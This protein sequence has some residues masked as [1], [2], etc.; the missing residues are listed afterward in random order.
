MQQLIPALAFPPG[1]I[2]QE[3]LEASGLTQQDLG[4]I[5]EGLPQTITEIIQGTQQITSET[6][7]YLSKAFGTSPEFWINLENN[8][9]LYLACRN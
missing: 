6:A 3:E 2:L 1:E 7:I 8:Y 4:A 5:E 9:R